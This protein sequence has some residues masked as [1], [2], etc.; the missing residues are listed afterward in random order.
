MSSDDL[1]AGFEEWALRG[2]RDTCRR[3]AAFDWSDPDSPVLDRRPG[4]RPYHRY[5]RDE[6]DAWQAAFAAGVNASG[7]A[8]SDVLDTLDADDTPQELGSAM[9]EQIH[10]L[11][12]T[13]ER[14]G[15]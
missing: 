12:P 8:A 2:V 4:N 10:K 7:A 13:S 6:W 9:L 11:L 5:M 3:D 1:R 15:A 14:S